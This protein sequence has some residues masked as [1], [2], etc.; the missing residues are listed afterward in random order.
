MNSDFKKLDSLI[1]AD[2]KKFKI[3]GLS[4]GIVKENNILLKKGFG[5]ADLENKILVK[6][7]TVF[8]FASISKTFTAIGIM[9]L[10]EKN[11]INLDD[12]INEYIPKG[13]IYYKNNKNLSITIKHLLTHTSGI[14][15]LLK[16]T[17]LFKIPHFANNNPKKIYSLERIFNRKIKLKTAP[18]TKWA[19]ANFGYMLLGYILEQITG[20]EFSEYMIENIF[21]P[22]EMKNTDFKRSERV[23]PLQ[24]K[25]Y[26]YK[27]G[28]FIE[29]GTELQT[30]MP[31][32]SL[33]SSI[34]DMTKFAICLLN[35]G[36]F[37]G[38]H[39]IKKE[40][41]EMMWKSQYSLDDRLP[42]MGYGFF[43]HDY[44]NFTI[45]NHG[46]SINGYL[47]ELYLIPEENLGIIVAINQNSLFNMNAIKIAHNILHYIL[48]IKQEKQDF[49]IKSPIYIKNYIGRYAP[50]KGFLTNFRYYMSG[51]EIKIYSKE[52]DLYYKTMWGGKRRGV[53]L[54]PANP[55]D[56]L[57]FKIYDKL[58]YDNIDPYEVII[59]IK[60]SEGK[61]ISFI[62]GYRE[63]FKR[64]WY[65]TFKFRLYYIIFGFALLLFILI[66]LMIG[67]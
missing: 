48:D 6:P 50:S 17:D 30:Q 14:G 54:Y 28:K 55:D 43:I 5:F 62:K 45:L 64:P 57:Y 49:K 39:I 42:A 33:Y 21:N 61:I 16:L 25:G 26:K 1:K 32:G 36:L 59:F 37:G 53:R 18:G 20:K 51:G 41:L 10:W 19:Y 23:R 63:Y 38:K 24:A 31:Q 60:N 27:K 7:N 13:S 15:E 47:S 56:S 2:M 52:N 12:N 9:Q 40:T 67:L 22:L 58:N 34:E 8:R 44:E 4:L 35:Y 11:L 65:K 29:F 46:G 66:S 3:P